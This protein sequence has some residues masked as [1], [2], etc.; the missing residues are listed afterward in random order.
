MSDGGGSSDRVDPPPD[1]VAPRPD[2]NV[3][4]TEPGA[5][6]GG[7]SR[8]KVLAIGAALVVLV[9]GGVWFQSVRG[10]ST[11]VE[12]AEIAVAVED[13][14]IAFGTN[15]PRI[16]VFVDYQCS[17]CADLDLVIGPEL[18]AMVGAEEAQLLLRPVNYVRPGSGRGAA[19]LRCAAESDLGLSL[20]EAML[21]NMDEDFTT[22]GLTALAGSLGVDEAEFGACLSDKATRR[23]VREVDAAATD[24]GMAALPSVYI[25]GRRLTDSELESGPALREAVTAAGG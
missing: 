2:P 5:A 12:D 23:W 10:G 22:D 19:A 17:H 7:T 20:H 14:G 4:N 6:T 1:P 13:T 24:D 21:A 9:G 11:E 16:E 8:L 15:G 18:K 3:T 25:D